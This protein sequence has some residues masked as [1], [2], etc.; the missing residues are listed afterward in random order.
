MNVSGHVAANATFS[1][2]GKEYTLTAP[3]IREVVELVRRLKDQELERAK[4]LLQG[5]PEKLQELTWN[6]ALE[7]V[8][9][10]EI[11]TD[12]FAQ[13]SNT[14]E[15]V[16][17]MFYLLV[18]KHHSEVTYEQALDMISDDFAAVADKLNSILAVSFGANPTNAE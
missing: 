5:L 1:F 3:T 13:A 12:E 9:K 6:R 2:K 8:S 7:R 10:I 17:Y 16:A 11:G 14:L 15:A 4:G 18:R